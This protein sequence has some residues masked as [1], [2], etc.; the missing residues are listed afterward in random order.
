M[1]RQNVNPMSRS[2]HTRNSFEK[3]QSPYNKMRNVNYGASQRKHTAVVLRKRRNSD[4]SSTPLLF[5]QK[6]NEDFIVT[7]QVLKTE[8]TFLL[9]LFFL[10]IL[11]GHLALTSFFFSYLMFV[12][13]DITVALAYVVSIYSHLMTQF[14]HLSWR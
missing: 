2:M 7:D 6:A 14:M 10:D 4:K 11:F 5:H 9:L 12:H 13:L 3:K 8:G 1:P